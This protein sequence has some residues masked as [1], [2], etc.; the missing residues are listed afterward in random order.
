MIRL[1]PIAGRLGLITMLAVLAT[2]TSAL[3]PVGASAAERAVVHF[4]DGRTLEVE[5]VLEREADVVLV[6]D[7]GGR[8]AVPNGRIREWA[9][10]PAPTPAQPAAPARRASTAQAWRHAAGDYAEM[11]AAAA[12][13][14]RVD[15]ALLTA[16]AQVESSFDPGAISPKGAQGL[17]QLMPATASRFG[18]RDAFDIEQNL[19]GGARYIKWL[20]ERYEGQTEL[21]LAGY[22]AGEAAVDRYRGIPPYPETQAYVTRVLERVDRFGGVP[23]P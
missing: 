3:S 10:L 5:Q 14:H 9:R 15:P 11:L 6:L 23:T 20:L 17:L 21:A 12:S 2:L 22:N 8:V 13:R 18:V 16:M 19:N 4:V 1:R 7:G